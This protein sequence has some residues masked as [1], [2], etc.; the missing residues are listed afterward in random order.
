MVSYAMSIM[1]DRPLTYVYSDILSEGTVLTPSMLM[2]GYRL[3]EPP[4]LNFRKKNSEELKLSEKYKFLEKVKDSFWHLW[5]TEYLTSLYEHHSTQ[6]RTKNNPKI[7][8]I[9]DIVLIRNE[10]QPRRNWK[11]ARILEVKV[12]QRDNKIR[13]CKVQTLSKKGRKNID[14]FSKTILRR[15]PNFLVP[16][17]IEPEYYSSDPIVDHKLPK[18]PNS[19]SLKKQSSAN[20]K[21]VAFQK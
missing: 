16:L 20:R 4:H 18:Q 6:G 21:K 2:H 10:K 8:K 13:E 19:K 3:L 17:E 14:N 9:G 12:S 7:P 15:S 1:N 5:S 11:L